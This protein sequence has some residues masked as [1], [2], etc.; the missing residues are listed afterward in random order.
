MLR[1]RYAYVPKAR[2]PVTLGTVFAGVNFIWNRK[3]VLGAVSLDLFAVLLAG[4]TSLL[5]VYSRDILHVGS[6]GLGVLAAGMGIGAAVTAVWFSIRPMSTNVGVKMLIAV[7]VTG[8]AAALLSLQSRVHSAQKT[9]SAE[10]PT[11]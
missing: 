2:E 3:P 11:S 10:S 9:N 1:L 6:Q 4:A 7:V 5:P 8:A